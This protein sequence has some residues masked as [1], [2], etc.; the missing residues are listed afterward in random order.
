MLRQRKTV[1]AWYDR[2]KRNFRISYFP[3]DAPVRP[4]AAYETKA[5]IEAIAARKHADIVWSPPLPYRFMDH[6]RIEI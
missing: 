1:F 4:S 2:A 6:D 3:P 5:E